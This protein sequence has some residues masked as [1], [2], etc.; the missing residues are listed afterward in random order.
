[1]KQIWVLLFS[2]FTVVLFGQTESNVSLL[3]VNEGLSQGQVFDVCQSRDGFLWVATKDGLNRYDGYRFEVFTNDSFDPF[4]IISNEVWKIFEDSRGWIWVA[5]PGGL[6]VLLPQTERF[7]HIIPDIRGLNGDSISFTE[8]PDG[9]IWIT[10]AGKLWK[11]EIPK[12]S[13]TTAA[14]AG[15]A[16]PELPVTRIESPGGL[17]STVYFSKKGTLLA[18]SSKGVFSVNPA[19]GSL[20]VEALAGTSVDIIGE[21]NH[22]RIWL[23]ALSPALEGLYYQA[24]YDMWVW[25]TDEGKPRLIPCLPYGRYKFD[26]NGF[27]WAWKYTDNTFQK[28]DPEKF[29]V[30]GPPE[31]EWANDQAFTQSPAYFPITI[32]FD[33]SGNLWLATNGFGML[34]VGFQNTGFSSYLPLTSQRMITESPDGDLY[35]Q[36]DYQKRYPS[37]GFRKGMP[38]P[39]AIPISKTERKTVITFDSKGNCWANKNADSLFLMVTPARQCPRKAMGLIPCKNRKLLS[40]SEKGLHQ[41]DPATGHSRLIPFDHTPEPSPTFTYSQFLYEDHEGTVWIF[42]FKGL[43]EATPDG[44]GYRFR[45]FKSH[46]ADRTS[47]SDNT[48][49]SVAADPL[50]PGR[51]LWVGTKGGGLNRLDRQAG[52]FQHYKTGQGLPDN[53]VYGI[54]P[55]DNGHLWLST[56]K[57]LCRFHIRDE[58]TRNFTVADGLQSNEFNQSSYLRTRD[59]HLIFGGINGLTVFHPDS[60]LFN[61]YQPTTAI[62]RVWINNQLTSFRPLQKKGNIPPALEKKDQQTLYLDLTHRQNLISL[63][64][65]ALEFTNP[66]QNQYRYHLA[67]KGFL[68]THTDN[69][70]VELGSKNSVQFANLRSGRY[71]FQVLGSNNDDAWSEQPAVLE[72]TIRPPWWL[73]WWAYLGYALLAGLMVNLI[74]HTQLRQRLQVQEAFRLKELDQFK[75]RFFV[76][77]TH[78]FRTPLTVILGLSRQL[79][80]SKKDLSEKE[81]A[82]K[83]DLIRRNGEN[84]LR[85]INQLLDLAKLESDKLKLNYIQGDVLPYLRYVVES[86]HSLAAVHNVGITIISAD[87]P[88]VLDYDPERLQQ[89]VFNLLSNAIKFTPSGGKVELEIRVAAASGQRLPQLILEV[90]DTG[91]GIS[92]ADLPHIFER[93]HQ[94]GHLEKALVGGTGIGLAL[95]RELVEAMEG[96]IKVESQPGQGTVFRVQLPIHQQAELQEASLPVPAG[97]LQDIG[98]RPSP[99][100][101]QELPQLLIV[102]DNPDVMEYLVS[103]LK[104][105]FAVQLAYN[106]ADGIEKAL[107]IVP[108]LIISDVMMP[109]KD[110]FE[111]CKVLKEDERTSHIP[112]VLLTARAEVKDRILGLRRGADAYLAKPFHEEELRATLDNLLEVRRHLQEK[113]RNAAF[114]APNAEA[115]AKS[116]PEQDFIQKARSIVLDHLPDVTFSVGT[117]CRSMA[118]SQPQ[119][120]RKLTALTGKNA[121]LFIRS[122]RLAKAKELLLAKGKNISEV[123]YEVGF[124]DPKYFS[125]VFSEEFG[126]SP[127]QFVNKQGL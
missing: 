83:L 35:L 53:V 39:W 57:G 62:T 31:L 116:D 76:N 51:F 109:Q 47:L 93:F 72:F 113:Y 106:G 10:V 42:A 108:D 55:D 16:F 58:S 110:G 36:S 7:F 119:L 15:N 61:E 84:L 89:V 13:L 96:E 26:R 78:E 114:T 43:I 70:W 27:L 23:I 95:T 107:E 56:N 115:S 32:A 117:F 33:R 81:F 124:S 24:Q 6:D 34:R 44:D 21:D 41:F 111:V 88:I 19:D 29:I 3:S 104:G 45:Y 30:G 22:G 85:L 46:P 25:N 68:S 97:E 102:E 94:A 82:L 28:W 40:V 20:Q 73:S 103:C 99:P 91:V 2:C 52:T 9:T 11:I 101:H 38:T 92:P 98:E 87:A 86:L 54:L 8:T 90:R 12:G 120:H 125:R 64:F 122:I 69:K 79:R 80:M 14:R 59:G 67:R 77:I 60:L 126:V 50:D 66:E 112:I 37:A 48:V 1:M 63:E 4:S 74:Y 5:C 75:N 123:A 71:T 105:T 118:M 18:A 65:A 49:L 100:G 17:F 121:T 127:Q